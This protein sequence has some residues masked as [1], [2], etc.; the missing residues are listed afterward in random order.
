M[1]TALLAEWKDRRENIEY[2]S[3]IPFG[4]QL[5]SVKK[6]REEKTIGELK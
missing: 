5:R 3:M 6:K 1:L 4:K 2:F